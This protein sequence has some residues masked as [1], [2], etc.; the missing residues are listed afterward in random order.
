MKSEQFNLIIES[1]NKV[2]QNIASILADYDLSELFKQSTSQINTYI[3]NVNKSKS[4]MDEVLCDFYHLIGMA[5]LS[6]PQISVLNKAVKNLLSY[7]N[8]MNIIIGNEP[9]IKSLAGGKDL[10]SPGKYKLKVLPKGK[11]ITLHAKNS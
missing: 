6:A 8:S 5:S 11:S 3:D 2:S 9:A 7:R 10:K 1:I 4:S